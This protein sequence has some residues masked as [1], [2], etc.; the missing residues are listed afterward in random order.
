QLEPLIDRLRRHGFNVGV[1]H[2]LRIELLLST[3]DADL[4]PAHLKSLL[5][6]LFATS[7]DEQF[8]F[9]QIF[10]QLYPSTDSEQSPA[11]ASSI[12][13]D[14]RVRV[15]PTSLSRGLRLDMWHRRRLYS[16]LT[17]LLTGLLI[18]L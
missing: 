13:A 9:Y 14:A 6:P 17:L 18:F 3:V 1:E 12:E 16:G 2:Y 4:D 7:E 15:T 10:E 8:L 5:C 11:T